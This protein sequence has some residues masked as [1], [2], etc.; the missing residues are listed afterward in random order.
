MSDTD[1]AWAAGFVDGEGCIGIYLS[2]K[3]THY[4]S[5]TVAGRQ[6]R[7]LE[8]LKKL[9]GGS[10]GWNN[11]PSAFSGGIWVWRV[12]SRNAA[13]ALKL[14]RP[15]MSIKVGQADLAI[16]FQNL[17][18]GKHTMRELNKFEIAERQS[19]YEAMRASK[20]IQYE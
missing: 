6:R 11:R 16:G 4:L 13:N 14:M 8:R 18:Q 3:K 15:H 17:M 2:H 19:F 5:L 7:P 1:T 20:S 10:V 12:H 9:F